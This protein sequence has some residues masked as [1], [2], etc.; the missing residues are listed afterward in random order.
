VPVGV[1]A[2]FAASSATVLAFTAAAGLGLLWL[3]AI[4]AQLLTTTPEAFR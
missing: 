2:G 1:V 3:T 4:T